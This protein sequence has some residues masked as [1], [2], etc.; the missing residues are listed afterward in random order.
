M[1]GNYKLVDASIQVQSTGAVIGF[2][3]PTIG[4]GIRESILEFLS[5][6]IY[7]GL[8]RFYSV[9][10][11]FVI[12]VFYGIFEFR[13]KKF[14]RVLAITVVLAMMLFFLSSFL[15]QL[16]PAQVSAFSFGHE[17]NTTSVQ[18]TTSNATLLFN[19]TF[20]SNVTGGAP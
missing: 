1:G 9:L 18:Y 19:N 2:I 13:R 7:L 6:P 10:P 8:F 14:Y 15:L 17:L 12:G 11:F 16:P 3:E 5:T 20:M 4:K